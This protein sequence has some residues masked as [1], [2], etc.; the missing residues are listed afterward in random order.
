M[1]DRGLTAPVRSGRLEES[2][3]WDPNVEGIE[4]SYGP[5][6]QLLTF[7]GSPSPSNICRPSNRIL[8]IGV[9]L[10]IFGGRGI[11]SICAAQNYRRGSLIPM[12]ILGS[13]E[14]AGRRL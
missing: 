5:N 1:I 4:L 12:S 8:R 2:P 7:L 13:K 6:Q 3:A 11:A 9:G 10:L 14:K